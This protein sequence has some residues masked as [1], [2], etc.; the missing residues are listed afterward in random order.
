M[1]T[2]TITHR[3]IG[4]LQHTYNHTLYLT[5]HHTQITE[6]K[7]EREKEKVSEGER[8]RKSERERAEWQEI[9]NIK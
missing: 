6:R 8:K 5:Q 7:R 1:H 3:R 4:S 9:S 2:H